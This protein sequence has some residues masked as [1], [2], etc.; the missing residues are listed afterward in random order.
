MQGKQPTSSTK[1][2]QFNRISTL[3]APQQ[4]RKEKSTSVNTIPIG[5]IAVKSAKVLQGKSTAKTVKN[6]RA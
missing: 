4:L 1:L 5:G 2:T 3:A 6:G